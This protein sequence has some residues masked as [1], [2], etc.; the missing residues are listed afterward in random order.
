MAENTDARQIRAVL[1]ELINALRKKDAKA[2]VA[3]YADD[4]V[5]Y[6][7]A[8]PLSIQGK[9]LRDPAGIQSWFDTWSGGIESKAQ[10]LTIRVGGDV[11]YAFSLQHM[12]GTKIDGERVDLWFR[13]TACFVRQ[14]GW[15]I[16]HV[17]NSVPFAMDGSDR[18][19]LDLKP[20]PT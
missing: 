5:A 18:A 16:T 8:P 10:K 4:A 12:T 7:L 2:A 17:H 11:A 1:D 19:L 6:D 14:G 13:A 3:A 20:D 9:E 15:K